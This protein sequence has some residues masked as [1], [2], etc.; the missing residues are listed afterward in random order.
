M[1]R[2]L[3]CSL[4]VLACELQAEGLTEKQPSD[5]VASPVASDATSKT[6]SPG[7]GTASTA[8]F[9]TK[10]NSS[11]EDYAGGYVGLGVNVGVHE[12]NAKVNKEFE[13]PTR[14]RATTF[15]GTVAFGFQQPVSGNFMIGF[16][17][18][19]DMGGT[20]K[21]ARIGGNI[22]NNSAMMLAY[23]DDYST[24]EGILRQMFDNIATSPDALGDDY[25]VVTLAG[26]HI[27][28]AGVYGRFVQAMRYFGGTSNFSIG[29]R[30][31]FMT[32]PA[33]GGVF[34]GTYNANAN[35]V[36]VDFIGERTAG[37]IRGL[38]GSNLQAG[39]AVM[40]EFIRSNFPTIADAL[41]HMAERPMM[42]ENPIAGPSVDP[43]G[44][45]NNDGTVD[46]NGNV[47]WAVA[48]ELSR[49]FG[50]DYVIYEYENIGVNPAGRNI[51]D[52]RREMED[53]YNPDNSHIRPR[54]SAVEMR[55]LSDFRSKTSF[56]ICPYAAIKFGYFVN[57]IN[58]L[59]YA[60]IGVTQLQGHVDVIN[61]FIEKKDKFHTIAPLVVV[62]ISKMLT[63]NCGVSI[64]VSHAPKTNKKL[65]DIEWKGYKVENNVGI[66]KTDLRILVTYT[67]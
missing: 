49:F 35:A 13:A 56:G 28:N 17:V 24:K 5:N 65:R 64:E 43:N 11:A 60:K 63:Q 59:F 20:G 40:H 15:S 37:N 58:G 2:F 53:L 36:F 48:R 47:H 7:S 29:N 46:V 19:A 12:T 62:G 38:S 25:P 50:G 66:S 23:R 31:N 8:I 21:R 1:S 14:F 45:V 57:E 27:I 41:G 33:G 9:D 44:N 54:L 18:G 10:I 51:A 16:E 42:A 55:A 26:S 30:N 52:L 6:E 67:F 34:D 32:A 22:R 39:Y 61:D 3:C 4:L